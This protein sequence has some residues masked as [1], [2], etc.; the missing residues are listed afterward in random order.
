MP[1]VW[2]WKTGQRTGSNLW[3]EMIQQDEEATRECCKPWNM[4]EYA[5]VF[6]LAM[7]G[8]TGKMNRK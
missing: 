1:E 4:E 2:K 5:D 3:L 7:T 6:S 8:R